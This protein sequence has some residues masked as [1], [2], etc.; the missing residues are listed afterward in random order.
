MC[1]QASKTEPQVNHQG[2]VTLGLGTTIFLHNIK[3]KSGRYEFIA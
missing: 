3:G 2:G 1:A